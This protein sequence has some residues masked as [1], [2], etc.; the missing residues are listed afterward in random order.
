[1]VNLQTPVQ[2]AEI[3]LC[4]LVTA[5][6]AAHQATT[7]L[8]ATTAKAATLHAR[9]A[10]A[11]KTTNAPLVTGASLLEE[12]A[13]LTETSQAIQ[14]EAVT[15]MSTTTAPTARHATA[16]AIPASAAAEMAAYLAR[17][18]PT[19]TWRHTA[20]VARKGTTWTETAPVCSAIL[21]ASNATDPTRINAHSAATIHTGWEE[22]A[23]AN[24]DTA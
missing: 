17:T 16:L 20:A 24:K 6:A 10:G 1:M 3:Q 15:R 22:A 5:R 7:S 19:I 23:T 4:Y 18:Q 12:F 21:A 11:L 14:E 13:E 2:A 8:P 9:P